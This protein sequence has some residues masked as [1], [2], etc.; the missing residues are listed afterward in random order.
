APPPERFGNLRIDRVGVYPG[1]LGNYGGLHKKIPVVTIELPNAR[2]MPSAHESRR[3]WDD[4][5]RW[6][7]IN[8]AARPLPALATDEAVQLRR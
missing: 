3:I 5:Q 1:S 8:L 4:M 6:I 7:A 2:A